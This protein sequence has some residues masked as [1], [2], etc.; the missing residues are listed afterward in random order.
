MKLAGVRL[1]GDDTVRI[2][3]LDGD[4]VQVVTGLARFWADPR[5][6]TAKAARLTGAGVPA[7]SV[8]FAPP[9][10]PSARVICVGLNYR[11]HAAEG[12]FEVPEH[13]TLFGR[14]TASLSVGDV[15]APV[16]TGEAGLDWEGEVAAYVAEPLADADPET[17]RAAVLGYS[18]FNDLTARRAQKLTTQWTLG[19]NGDRSGPMGPI[20]TADEAGD[21]R[22][23]LRVLTRVNGTVVQDGNTRDMIFDVGYVLSLI[24]RTFT[25]NPGDVIAT[26]TPDGV[27]YVRTPP[28]LLQPGDVVEVEI[29]RLGVLRTPIVSRDRQPEDTR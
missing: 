18:T 26:G 2:A 17:A 5:G 12:S 11:A 22:D 14:W 16:P 6:W 3:R 29:D 9:V 21:P 1:A 4:T 24:S 13:P 25:L 10:P 15:P 8:R 23:G 28:W 19:K 27:G 20:V 7:E